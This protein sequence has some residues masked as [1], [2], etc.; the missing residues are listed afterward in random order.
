MAVL[1]TRTLQRRQKDGSDVDLVLTIFEPAKNA[2]NDWRCVFDFEPPIKPRNVARRG[3]DWVG[4]FVHGLEYARLYF[5]SQWSRTGHWQGM[6]HLGL[7]DATKEM[8][9]HD[10]QK[11][12][13]LEAKTK[14]LSVLA[15]RR[16]GI[17]G[18]DGSVREIM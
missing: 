6:A 14:S 12:P 5:E 7:P 18:E 17:P 4:A 2:E 13:P 3:V 11:L 8:P 9:M 16:L 1:T 10:A 15:T